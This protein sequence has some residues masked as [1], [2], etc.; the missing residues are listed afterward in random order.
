MTVVVFKNLTVLEKKSNFRA[1]IK[2][3]EPV[4]KSGKI[5]IVKFVTN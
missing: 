2:R 3:A 1:P 5:K 4:A